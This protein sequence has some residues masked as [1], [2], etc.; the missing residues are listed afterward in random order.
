MSYYYNTQKCLYHS[1]APEH[2]KMYTVITYWHSNHTVINFHFN[3]WGDAFSRIILSQ[4]RTWLEYWIAITLIV[5]NIFPSSVIWYHHPFSFREW[6][7]RRRRPW[8]AWPFME[9][10]FI[11]DSLIDLYSS[12]QWLIC[13]WEGIWPE[14]VQ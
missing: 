6:I 8:G 5:Y 10:T 7:R 3:F 12:G 13:W 11:G 9:S 2:L 1:S 14:S 4:Q